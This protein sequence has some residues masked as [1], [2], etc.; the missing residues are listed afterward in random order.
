MN[1]TSFGDDELQYVETISGGAGAV[2]VFSCL[3]T[4]HSIQRVFFPTRAV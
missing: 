3:I 1:V 4:I 2:S